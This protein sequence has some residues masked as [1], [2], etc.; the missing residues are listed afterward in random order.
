[1]NNEIRSLFPVV[2][3]YI[4]L[5]HSQVC[6][7]ST[8]VVDAM[9][10]IIADV[11]N[12]GVV[13]EDKWSDTYDRVRASAAKLI[14]A[15]PH[16]IAFMRNTSDAISAVANGIDWK[17]GDNIVTC[18]VEFPA[19]VYPWMRVASAYG[20]DIKKATERDG[21]VDPDELLS[22]IDERT[23]VLA[24]SWVQF[25]SGFRSD[26]RKIG[27]RCR[28]RGV[29]F[30]VDAIQGLGGLRLDVEAD[31]V[32]AVAADGHK[33]LLGPEGIALLYVSDSVIDRIHPTTVG[34]MSVEEP[35]HY[36]DYQLNYRRG[37]G[38]F[39][40]GSF[41]TIGLYG[42][43][44]AIELFLEIGPAK[45]EEHLL[46]LNTYL[47]DQ[48]EARKFEVISSRK[49]GEMSAVVTCQHAA[50]P[51]G[52]LQQYLL[53][54]NIIAASRLGRLRISPHFYNTRED[55]DALLA[56]LPD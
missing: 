22:L 39:E 5:N 28:E 8:R 25:G 9:S 18:N 40:C 27:R 52:E 7:L 47:S 12:N 53:S 21:R 38:R 24:L 15:R 13:H 32:D 51:A 55:I 56:V 35:V 44:A 4:Y 49:P 31:C 42:L 26:L 46:A 36:L 23:K 43:G 16:E 1:M 20:V 10:G 14:N 50:H 54:K 45:I 37:A 17:A 33:Y 11:A 19:N 30:A 2:K 3:K 29:I 48:L 41:N 6:P 34:W